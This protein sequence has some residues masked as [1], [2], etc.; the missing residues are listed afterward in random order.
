MIPT[1]LS[2]EVSL[3]SCRRGAGKRSPFLY[4]SILFI[5]GEYSLDRPKKS[6]N[7]RGREKMKQTRQ[8]YA[9]E[10]WL[11]VAIVAFNI[12]TSRHTASRR[13]SCKNFTLDFDH[14]FS[15]STQHHSIPEIVIACK[16]FVLG[17][18]IV[19]LSGRQSLTCLCCRMFSCTRQAAP[20]KLP[21][22]LERCT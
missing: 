4:D 18:V 3:R 13:H 12:A 20:S 9:V 5:S 11:P 14:D 1:Q 10:R 22:A 16:C 8:R 15:I 21:S 7:A 2:S 17:T 19:M 6:E